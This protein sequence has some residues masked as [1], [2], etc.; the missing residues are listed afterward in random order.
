[1]K[2]LERPAYSPS[3]RSSSSPNRR[4]RSSLA[5]SGFYGVAAV[6]ACYTHHLLLVRLAAQTE[7]PHVARGPGKGSLVGHS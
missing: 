7:R 2:K 4:A 6:G 1:M 5:F 3:L